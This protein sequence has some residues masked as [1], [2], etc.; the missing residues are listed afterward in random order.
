MGVP[1]KAVHMEKLLQTPAAEIL[2]TLLP[3]ARSRHGSLAY[4]PQ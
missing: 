3:K 2:G 4:I 1:V